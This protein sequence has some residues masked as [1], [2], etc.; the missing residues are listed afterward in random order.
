MQCLQVATSSRRRHLE[1]LHKARESIELGFRQLEIN[2]SPELAA[3]DFRS[4]QNS[5]GEITGKFTSD[6]LL[7]R[8]FAGFCIGK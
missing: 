8:I 2:A 3:E 5:L 6:D 1:A 4:A 7:G